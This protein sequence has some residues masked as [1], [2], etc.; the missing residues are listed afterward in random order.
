MSEQQVERIVVPASDGLDSI[1]V[2]LEQWRN[3]SGDFNSGSITAVCYGEAWNFVA[4]NFGDATI[5]QFL[6]GCD[7][8][9]LGNKF[10][11]G[12]NEYV[13]DYE[14]ISKKLGFEIANEYEVGLC[15]KQISEAFGADFAHEL[16]QTKNRKFQYIVKIAKRIIDHLNSEPAAEAA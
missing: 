1:I 3:R 6:T 8:H 10:A 16:P 5:R 14:A 7:E 9:Y 13:T 11:Y 12:I 15:D 2:Y 4:G